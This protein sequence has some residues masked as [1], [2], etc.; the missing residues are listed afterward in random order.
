MTNLEMLSPRINIR[1]IFREQILYL[2]N[3]YVLFCCNI[4][5]ETFLV[6]RRSSVERTQKPLL[7]RYE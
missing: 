3:A 1:L 2:L 4:K 7:Q 6:E 5:R